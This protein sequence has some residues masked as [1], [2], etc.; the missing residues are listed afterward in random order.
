MRDAG[1][2][3]A[4][5]VDVAAPCDPDIVAAVHRFVAISPCML[6]LLQADDLAGEAIALNLPATDRERPNWRR[7]VGVA[8]SELWRT[9]AG[10]QAVADGA[11]A[12]ATPSDVPPAT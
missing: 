10:A 12:R 4:A 11:A 2:A 8:A 1:V 3:G 6:A 7:R 5:D 9:P